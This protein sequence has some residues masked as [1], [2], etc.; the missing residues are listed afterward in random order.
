[1]I[2]CPSG[3]HGVGSSSKTAMP[4]EA[5]P[6]SEIGGI[7]EEV[8]GVENCVDSCGLRLG[9]TTLEDKG[10]LSRESRSPVAA[11]AVFGTQTWVF[12]LFSVRHFLAI[13]P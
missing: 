12:F 9:E 2:S 7:E 4:G 5:A 8:D 6:P 3:N 10:G 13:C 1:M 11:L